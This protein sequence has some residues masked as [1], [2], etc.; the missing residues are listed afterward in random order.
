MR[1][2]FPFDPPRFAWRTN[3]L[4]NNLMTKVRFITLLLVLMSVS[5]SGC[6]EWEPFDAR[7][8]E[9]I[10]SDPLADHS[11]RKTVFG[12]GGMSIFGEDEPRND[13]GALGVNSYL[14]RASLD[15]I[16]FMPVN[17]ADPFGGV[18]ITDWHTPPD[19]PRE[20]FKL[21]VYILGRSLRAD[22][23]RVA[24]FRQVLGQNGV[25]T[26]AAVPES[27]RTKIED[28]ILTKARQIR[29]ANIVKKD[30]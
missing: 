20:R 1:G 14:W 9:E 23:V 7:K 17:S 5:L 27:T 8:Q 21:N 16:S 12:E 2:A 11:K 29:N 19:S 22:G 28:A 30:N 15:T 13:G 18:I 4:G 25:W 24:V 3:A 6:A 10:D 26:D